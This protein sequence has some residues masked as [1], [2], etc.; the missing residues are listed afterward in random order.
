[1]STTNTTL[2]FA[3]SLPVHQTAELKHVASNGIQ[4]AGSAC[5]P[6]PRAAPAEVSEQSEE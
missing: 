4:H 5:D 3:T 1:M 2:H 6:A